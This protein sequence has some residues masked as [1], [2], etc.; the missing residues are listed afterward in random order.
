MELFHSRALRPELPLKETAEHLMQA[1]SS[2]RTSNIN[3]MMDWL[4]VKL[5]VEDED[6]AMLDIKYF[7]IY[8]S[9]FGF[10]IAVDGIH[11]LP[12]SRSLFYVVIISL[13]PPSSLYTESKIPTNDVSIDFILICI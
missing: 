9:D 5:S 12:K 8:D 10:K 7:A 13:N 4:D 6:P 2:K 1:L 3:T 11:N